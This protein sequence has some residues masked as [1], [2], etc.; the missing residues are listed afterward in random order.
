MLKDITDGLYS[1]YTLNNKVIEQMSNYFEV[2]K[3]AMRIRLV[4]LNLI[5]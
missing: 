1:E 2:S 4:N 5:S 3:E